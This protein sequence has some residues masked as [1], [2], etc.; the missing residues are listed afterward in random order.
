M[1]SLSCRI[2]T[3]GDQHSVK[4]RAG[5]TS[6]SSHLSTQV[7]LCFEKENFAVKKREQDV[8]PVSYFATMNF[9]CM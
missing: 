9:T 2:F 3:Q 6:I 1:K 5:V 4:N 8:R 7:N